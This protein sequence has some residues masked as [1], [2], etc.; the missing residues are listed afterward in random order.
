MCIT[1]LMLSNFHCI[2]FWRPMIIKYTLRERHWNLFSFCFAFA[3]ISAF[4]IP[5]DKPVAILEQLLKIF[6]MSKITTTCHE[7]NSGNKNIQQM[8]LCKTFF[9]SFVIILKFIQDTQ[10]EHKIQKWIIFFH[11]LCKTLPHGWAVQF[12]L[13]SIV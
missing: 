8:S 7:F 11:V 6:A 1:F 10:F 2:Y 13:V 4:C 12:G 5:L 3:L 9:Y